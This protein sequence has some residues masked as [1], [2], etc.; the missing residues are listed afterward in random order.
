MKLMK[1]LACLILL[2]ATASLL[3]ACHGTVVGKY[4][5]HTASHAY[6]TLNEDN[7]FIHEEKVGLTTNIREGTYSFDS[8]TK[9]LTM[10]YE[11]HHY[12]DWDKMV[13]YRW[14]GTFKD[15]QYTQLS[16]DGT[17]YQKK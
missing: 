3:T 12:I 6:L 14:V 5:N 7:T 2:I 10:Y 16:L 17:I 11:G 15:S 8:K 1:R 4:E 13:T 9:E